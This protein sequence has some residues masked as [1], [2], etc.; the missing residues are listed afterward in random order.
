MPYWRAQTLDEVGTQLAAAL[1]CSGPTLVEVDMKAIGPF[2]PK[3][4]APTYAKK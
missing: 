2:T 1:R 3:F 4:Q